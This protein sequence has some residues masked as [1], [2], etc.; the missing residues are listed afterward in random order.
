MAIITEICTGASMLQLVLADSQEAK[1]VSLPSQG[2]EI[3][4]CLCDYEC[5]YTN[6]VFASV[7]DDNYKNDKSNFL[8]SLT[9]DTSVLEIRLVG[10]GNDILINDNTYGGYFAKGSFDNTENQIN[11]VGFIA[12]WKKIFDLLGAGQYYFTFKET[13][14]NQDFETES[15]KYQL[16]IFSDVL[17]NKSVRFNFVQNGVIE[18]GLDY[19]GL[20]WDT[21][22]RIKAKVRYQ[23]PILTVDNFQNSNRKITQIQDKTIENFEIETGLIPSKI[24]DLFVKTGVV[25]NQI[26]FTDYNLFAYKKYQEFN[27]V[28]TEI[29]DFK[30]NYNLNSTGSF[31]FIAEERIQNNVKRNVTY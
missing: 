13:V 24:G 17:A 30:G 31:T 1:N 15:V 3:D 11:Y 22:I 14:F 7:E 12:D 18:G 21:E 23:A 6:Q 25:S 4:F 19:T 5:E 20:N 10:N 28:I 8:I 2:S 16:Q 9:D 29:S 26:Y 27:V